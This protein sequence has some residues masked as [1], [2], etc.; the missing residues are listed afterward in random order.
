[1]RIGGDTLLQC[2]AVVFIIINIRNQRVTSRIE[3]KTKTSR[4]ARVRAS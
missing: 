1:M 2:G 3:T 4:A